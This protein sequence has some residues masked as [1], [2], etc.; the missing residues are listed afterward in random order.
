MPPKLKDEW[1]RHKSTFASGWL[2]SMV[3]RRRVIFDDVPPS[4]KMRREIERAAATKPSE[5]KALRKDF[6]LIEAAIA[7]D[8][9]VV[10]LDETVR[11]LFRTASRSVAAIEKVVWVNPTNT[12]E[13]SVMWLRRGAKPEN[14][15]MLGHDAHK[16]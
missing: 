4:N 14:A 11:K 15:R 6:H 1:E 13:E 3:S 5:V 7:T 8:R 10:S 2:V 12:A 16:R 9:I